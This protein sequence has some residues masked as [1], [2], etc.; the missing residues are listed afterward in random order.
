MARTLDGDKLL[1]L[2]LPLSGDTPVTLASGQDSPFG[3]AVDSTS[4]YWVNHATGGSVMKAT[5]K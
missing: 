5:P 1:R 2:Q 3:I 4:V